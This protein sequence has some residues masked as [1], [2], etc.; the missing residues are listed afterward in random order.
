VIKPLTAEG[1]E[2]TLF[3]KLRVM[4]MFIALRFPKAKLTKRKHTSQVLVIT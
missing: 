3:V 4:D 1:G 2:W